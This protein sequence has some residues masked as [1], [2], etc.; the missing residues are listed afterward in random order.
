MVS[1]LF[2]STKDL[3][4]ENAHKQSTVIKGL[5]GTYLYCMS[6]QIFYTDIRFHG[7]KLSFVNTSEYSFQ[8]PV[9]KLYDTFLVFYCSSSM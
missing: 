8:S 5:R 2:P 6:S 4:L 1:F 7:L 9:Y 3:V